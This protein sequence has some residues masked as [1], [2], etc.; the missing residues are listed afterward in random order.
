MFVRERWLLLE[1]GRIAAR[2]F[3]ATD[4]LFDGLQVVILSPLQS[5]KLSLCLQVVNLY[6]HR[7][8]LNRVAVPASAI[9]CY[10][11]GEQDSPTF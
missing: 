3:N 7:I 6:L 1:Q 11:V 5:A 10:D 4:D 8:Y 2:P 9:T